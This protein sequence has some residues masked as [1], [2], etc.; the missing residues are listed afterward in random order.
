MCVISTYPT[1]CSS[2]Q[3]GFRHESEVNFTME[4]A[5][6]ASLLQK[7]TITRY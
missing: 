3:S 5:L 1:E 7:K 6:D 2:H 4:Q